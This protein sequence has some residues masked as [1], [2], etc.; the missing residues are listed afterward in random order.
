MDPFPA[1]IVI[2][3]NRIYSKNMNRPHNYGPIELDS[4]TPY[5]KNPLI[6]RVFKEIG[7]PEQK[8]QYRGIDFYAQRALVPAEFYSGK[9]AGWA[10]DAWPSSNPKDCDQ[11]PDAWPSSNPK[12]C[13]QALDAWPSSNPKDCDQARVPIQDSIR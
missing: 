1:K 7:H 11:A 6:A 4:F 13:D 2:E 12:D 3:T 10:P 8:Y 9:A 5:P